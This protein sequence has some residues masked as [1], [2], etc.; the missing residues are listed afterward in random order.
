MLI[1]GGEYNYFNPSFWS[2]N[3]GFNFEVFNQHIQDDLLLSFGSLGVKDENGGDIN[4]FHFAVK[5]NI[6]YSLDGKFVGL[7][8]GIS[9]SLGIYDVPEFP[10]IFDLSFAATGFVG[11]CI[12]PNS[13]VSITL[14]VCP[15]YAVAFR[16]TNFTSISPN[17]SGFILPI[18]LG[19]RLNL[20][21]L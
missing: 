3:I 12:F 17:D 15:G 13:L 1:V 5:D 4:R 7:R 19:L 21:K 8:T 6:F 18:V 11:I 20:D 9:A 14:D 16:S 2:G 10:K